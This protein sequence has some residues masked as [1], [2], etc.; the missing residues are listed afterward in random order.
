MTGAVF[1]SRGM[2]IQSDI[3]KTSRAGF[4]DADLFRSGMGHGT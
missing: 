1:P 3:T 2:A 4:F